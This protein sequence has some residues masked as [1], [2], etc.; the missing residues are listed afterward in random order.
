[1]I[2]IMT[3]I[4]L[5]QVYALKCKKNPTMLHKLLLEFYV[6]RLFVKYTW[7]RLLFEYLSVYICVEIQL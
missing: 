4:I 7:L 6:A 1:M 3:L 5:V 2:L